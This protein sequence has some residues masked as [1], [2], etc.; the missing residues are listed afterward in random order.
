MLWQTVLD[1]GSDI[2]VIAGVIT[3]IIFIARPIWALTQRL[4]K[5]EAVDSLQDAAIN[6]SL[7]ER[8]VMHKAIR[9]VLDGL[10]QLGANG[11]VTGS[12]E[13]MDDYVARQAHR[14]QENLT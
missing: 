14:R 12:I 11:R 5:K 3:A 1:I 13:E 9:A 8:R 2:I 7:E 10:V 6:Q 4:D